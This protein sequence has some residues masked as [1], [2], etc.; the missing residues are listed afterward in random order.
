M[1]KSGRFR[2]EHR[3]QKIQLYRKVIDRNQAGLQGRGTE[4]TRLTETELES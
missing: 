1:V 2:R 3:R 4:V